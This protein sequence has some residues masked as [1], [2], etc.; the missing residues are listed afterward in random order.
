M[1]GISVAIVKP[2]VGNMKIINICVQKGNN[3]IF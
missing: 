3:K 2:C 1:I